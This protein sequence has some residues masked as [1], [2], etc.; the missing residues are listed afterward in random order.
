MF[1]DIIH[2]HVFIKTHNVSETGFCLR[3]HVEPISWAQSIELVPIHGHLHEHKIG[4]IKQAQHK[5]SARAKI[6]H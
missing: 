3:L 2:R 6:K 5:P 1:L 4:H